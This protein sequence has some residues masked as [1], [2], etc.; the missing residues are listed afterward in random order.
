MFFGV[1]LLIFQF[2]YRQIIYIYVFVCFMLPYKCF[3]KFFLLSLVL[4]YSM[5]L[6]SC[7]AFHVLHSILNMTL[8]NKVNVCVGSTKSTYSLH[9]LD[10]IW[11]PLKKVL[12]YLIIILYSE[13]GHWPNQTHL[14]AL[15][16]HK[17]VI[18]CA[19]LFGTYA[20]EIMLHIHLLVRS[21]LRGFACRGFI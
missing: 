15:F 5:Q 6:V 21:E 13:S 10:S 8:T 16:S 20:Y 12:K 11:I 2:V 9:S 18:R 14:L 19:Q 1:L 3:F 7:I 17:T 4:K